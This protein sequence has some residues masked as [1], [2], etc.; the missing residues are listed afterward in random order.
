MKQDWFQK[1]FEKISDNYGYI[2]P[3]FI[4]NLSGIF[5]RER[6]DEKEED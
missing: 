1:N 3:E 5:S 4:R 6:M 2:C